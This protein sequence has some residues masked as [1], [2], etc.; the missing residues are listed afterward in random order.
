LKPEIELVGKSLSFKTK[1]AKINSN[2][3]LKQNLKNEKIKF[4][5]VFVLHLSKHRLQMQRSLE[6]GG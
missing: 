6:L 5:F 2:W 4:L 1:L 3:T